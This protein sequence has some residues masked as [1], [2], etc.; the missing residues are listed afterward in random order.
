VQVNATVS[1]SEPSSDPGTITLTWD[2]SALSIEALEPEPAGHRSHTQHKVLHYN[3]LLE[4]QREE[5]YLSTG[6][7]GEARAGMS[8]A[9]CIRRGLVCF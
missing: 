3:I 7:T 1:R 4:R 5:L 2:H 8:W 6:K 9:S